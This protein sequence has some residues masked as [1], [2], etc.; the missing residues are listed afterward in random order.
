[1]NKLFSSKTKQ[2]GSACRQAGF[3]NILIILIGVGLAIFAGFFL[4]ANFKNDNI[5]FN[6]TNQK[7]G[8]QKKKSTDKIDKAKNTNEHG[9]EETV[10]A[11]EIYDN[12]HVQNLPLCQGSHLL[13]SSPMDLDK[14]PIIIPRGG[15][16]PLGHVLPSDHGGI[17]YPRAWGQNLYIEET[18]IKAPGDGHIFRIERTLYSRNGKKE[19]E[20]YDIAFSP[21]R[22]FVVYMGHVSTISKSLQKI[23]DLPKE[24]CDT[25]KENDLEYTFC[26]YPKVDYLT[27]S[28][29]VIGIVKSDGI[30]VSGMDFGAFDTRT[31]ELKFLGN[32][33]PEARKLQT[34]HNVCPWD[35]YSSPLKEQ[36]FDK[37][38][39]KSEPK[40]GSFMQDKDGTIA[41]NW[42]VK[43]Y[44]HQ[45]SDSGDWGQQ[46]AVVHDH[47]NPEIGIIAFGGMIHEPGMLGFEPTHTG[48]INREPT[49]VTADGKI[50]C[51][52]MGEGGS[53]SNQKSSIRSGK[54][55]IQLLGRTTLKAEFQQGSC[56]T[57]FKFNSPTIYER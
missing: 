46:F 19:K 25:H 17:M 8:D 32:F 34:L 24:Y 12:S 47:I 2:T 22:E 3:A 43:D 20:D 26:T 1:M 5:G 23:I 21:C 36:L 27:H 11:T 9:Q 54:I 30:R 41:G 39:A 14:I 6:P 38:A 50:Y 18:E 49:E 56:D 35:Y 57:I 7:A 16:S 40:C 31:A 51:Y 52:A 42:Q 48:V 33:Y 4:W 13:V 10:Q 55:L 45:S 53:L 37:L 15:I 29:E 44:Q 28:G